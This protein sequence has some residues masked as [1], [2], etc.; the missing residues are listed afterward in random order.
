MVDTDLVKKNIFWSVLLQIATI[1][2]GFILPRQLLIGFGSETNGLV[3]SLNQFLNYVTL[4]EGGVSGV[5]TAAL[6]KTLQGK[7][8]ESIV[9]NHDCGRAAL[10]HAGSICGG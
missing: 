6:Y 1:V 8:E 3:A 9:S 4:L 5:A 2:S 7:N 10:Q